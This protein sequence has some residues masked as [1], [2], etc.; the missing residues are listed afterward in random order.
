MKNLTK[1][2]LLTLTLTAGLFAEKDTSTTINNSNMMVNNPGSLFSSEKLAL[3]FKY[4]GIT[5]HP[6]GGEN[7]EPYKRSLDDGDYWVLLLGFQADADYVVNRFLFIRTAT[8]LYRDCA[9]VWSGYFNL[10]FRVNWWVTSKLGLRIGVGPTLLWRENWN[11]VV[12]GYTK[13]SFYGAAT[14]DTFQSKFI[15]HGGD[16]EVEWKAW[17]EISLIYG[18]IPGYPEVIQNSIGLRK[19]F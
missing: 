10:G 12:K 1:A 2:L 14:D 17:E 3:G 6:G 9:D 4:T 5:Y 15:W 18:F 7:E 16:V 11:G 8:S 13:D 19:S